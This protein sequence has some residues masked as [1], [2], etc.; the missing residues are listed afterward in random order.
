MW[1]LDIV[2]LYQTN[3]DKKQ[4]SKQTRRKKKKKKKTLKN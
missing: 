2:F 4:K 3:I 1:Q